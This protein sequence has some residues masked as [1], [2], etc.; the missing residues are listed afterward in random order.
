MKTRRW[1]AVL[2]AVLLTMG[3]AGQ[4]WAAAANEALDLTKECTLKVNPCDSKAQGNAEMAEELAKADIVIDM[5]RVAE[6]KVEQTKYS[7]TPIAPF[8][9]EI[10]QDI[11]QGGWADIAQKAAAKV[12]VPAVAEPYMT[13]DSGKDVQ[14][15][16]GIY[17]LVA[18]KRGDSDY[19]KTITNKEG[20]Q[21]IVTQVKTDTHMYTFNP[22]LVSLPSK[23]PEDGVINT[24]NPGEW[25]YELEVNLKPE[26]SDLKGQLEIVKTLKAYETS[27]PAT[28]VFQID[29]EENGV[30]RSDVRSITFTA[31]GER[32]LT[33]DGLPVGA[34]VTVREVYSG[35]VYVLETEPEQTAVIMADEIARVN[36]VNDYDEDKPP[37][38]GGSITNRFTYDD[39]WKVEKLVDNT[40]EYSAIE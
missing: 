13:A 26:R 31:P 5:Y 35:T 38:D 15:P 11:T 6:W 3:L 25:L 21:V 24:A 17:L 34:V 37:N 19:V 7:F 2:I 4:I 9:M 18:H 23:A 10:P 8:D 40:G 28:F 22:E 29:W 14:L 12:L 16:P 32:V 30:H 20:D 36:F 33:V 39:G 27:A 1:L